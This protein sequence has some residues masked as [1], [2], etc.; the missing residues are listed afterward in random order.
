MVKKSKWNPNI[1]LKKPQEKEGYLEFYKVISEPENI[2]ILWIYI[3]ID[4]YECEHIF[5]YS[6]M[7][8]VMF[9]QKSWRVR[10]RRLLLVYAWIKKILLFKLFIY[11]PLLKYNYHYN[12]DYC[13]LIMIN[14]VIIIITIII[15]TTLKWLRSRGEGL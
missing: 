12:Y 4:F 15:F 6:Y 2:C 9:S 5:L 7:H 8:V 11:Y 13:H 10:E 14:I 3:Y 1:W